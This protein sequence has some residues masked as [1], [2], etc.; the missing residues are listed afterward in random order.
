MVLGISVFVEQ[1]WNDKLPLMP[2]F[3]MVF[4]NS[5]WCVILCKFFFSQNHLKQ[6]VLFLLKMSQS[7]VSQAPSPEAKM[8]LIS[9]VR[10][11][12]KNPV[13]CNL[14]WCHQFEAIYCQS[15]LC[16]YSES[17]WENFE[18]YSENGVFR[19]ELWPFRS[20]VFTRWEV[21][22]LNPFIICC[23]IQN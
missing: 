22:S 14:P 2:L 18:S 12:L 23:F 17:Y 21:R 7:G 6:S 20:I 4:P 15:E 1:K 9:Y 5:T 10:H 8:R 11:T 3:F 16:S 13:L 19:R